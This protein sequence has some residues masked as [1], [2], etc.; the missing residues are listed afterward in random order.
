MFRNGKVQ[1]WRDDISNMYVYACVKKEEKL[2]SNAVSRSMEPLDSK[3]LVCS[4]AKE[5][6]I[7]PITAELAEE[8]SAG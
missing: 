5:R 1:H 8:L 7:A 2:D 4:R 3:R 6:C